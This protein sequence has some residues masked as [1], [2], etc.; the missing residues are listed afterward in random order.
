MPQSTVHS[1]CIHCSAHR[2]LT[3]APQ[4][5]LIDHHLSSSLLLTFAFLPR[6]SILYS[7]F[8]QPCDVR[9]SYR[10]SDHS[11][12]PVLARHSFTAR[13]ACDICLHAL[14]DVLI[15]GLYSAIFGPTTR[16]PESQRP[17]PIQKKNPL[18]LTVVPDTDSTTRQSICNC[19]LVEIVS[20]TCSP[21]RTYHDDAL[22]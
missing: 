6:S 21:H 12:R 14:F 2:P 11:A 15:H 13:L 9:R 17:T 7:T 3:P 20:S 19:L 22:A 18:H 16:D 10:L 4:S 8:L 1:V 5:T